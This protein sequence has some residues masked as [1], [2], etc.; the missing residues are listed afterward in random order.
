MKEVLQYNCKTGTEI[1][2]E[3]MQEH[4]NLGQSIES[5]RLQG[6]SGKCKYE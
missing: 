5:A 3:A 1:Q 6:Y 4:Y 2:K